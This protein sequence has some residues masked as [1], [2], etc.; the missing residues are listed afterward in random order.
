VVS[1]ENARKEVWIAFDDMA[2]FEADEQKLMQFITLHKGD[3]ETVVYLRQN[4]A[5]KKLGP[6]H[7]ISKES[8][9]ELENLFGKENVK[10]RTVGI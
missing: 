2:N 5:M 6:N 1:F 9:A 8:A 7:R 10:F 3:C 4:K